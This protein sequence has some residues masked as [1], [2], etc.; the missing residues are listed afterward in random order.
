MNPMI[1]PVVTGAVGGLVLLVFL[2]CAV[3]VALLACQFDREWRRDPT[4][5]PDAEGVDR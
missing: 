5:R 2:G 4:N 1:P 3:L